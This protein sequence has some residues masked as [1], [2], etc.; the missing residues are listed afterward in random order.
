M[1]RSSDFIPYLHTPMSMVDTST[2]DRDD[3]TLCVSR[4]LRD[5]I[6]VAKAKEGVSYDDYLSRH[7]P[8]ETDQ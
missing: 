3:T 6:R 4:E 5:E 2:R 7:L 8:I 1:L